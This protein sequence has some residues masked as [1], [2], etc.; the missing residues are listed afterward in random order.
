[1]DDRKRLGL[2]I[3]HLRKIRGYTQ[4]QLAEVVDINAKYLSSVE[5]GEENPTLDLLLRLAGGLKVDPHELFQLEYEGERS[6][7]LRKKL[8]GLVA[9]VK[10][11]DLPRIVRILEVLLH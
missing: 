10:E 6:Q 11:E 4:E 2:R 8:E 3:K 7:R 1:M 9:R 5:R